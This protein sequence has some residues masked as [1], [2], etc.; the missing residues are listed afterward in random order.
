MTVNGI[1]KE[2]VLEFI[3]K[4]QKS[5]A[6]QVK[7]WNRR[8]EDLATTS[9]EKRKEFLIDRKEEARRSLVAE[10]G[11]IKEFVMLLGKTTKH[12]DI[13]TKPTDKAML[14]DLLEVRS[15]EI[16]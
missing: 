5:E 16:I 7:E 12:V 2:L 6:Y 14:G 15:V 4:H 9:D 3:E 11:I 1:E 10:Q 8:A 13:R